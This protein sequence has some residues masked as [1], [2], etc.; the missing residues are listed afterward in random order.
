MKKLII[1]AL[2]LAL[3]FSLTACLGS[4][5]ESTVNDIYAEKGGEI[6]LPWSW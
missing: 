2:T 5:R 1:L 6:T 4:Q 3:A